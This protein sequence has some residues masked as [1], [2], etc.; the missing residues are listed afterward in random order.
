MTMGVS[1]TFEAQVVIDIH[2]QSGNIQT[3]KLPSSLILMTALESTCYGLGIMMFKLPKRQL[4]EVV[5]VEAINAR[6]KLW[7]L[8]AFRVAP[9]R[10]LIEGFNEVV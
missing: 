4:T 3:V 8:V 2:Q 10:R 7:C 1:Q 6:K 5:I 9:L